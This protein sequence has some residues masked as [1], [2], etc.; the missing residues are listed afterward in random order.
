MGKTYSQVRPG[1]SCCYKLIVNQ[2]ATSTRGYLTAQLALPL[3]L[4]LLQSLVDNDV[5]WVAVGVGT[6]WLFHS[7][8]SLFSLS[9]LAGQ[10]VM[11]A[12]P[13]VPAVP[14]YPAPLSVL[15]LASALG[16]LPLIYGHGLA[17]LSD[18]RRRR[19][20][21]RLRQRCS[22]SGVSATSAVCLGYACPLHTHSD[23]HTH[24][25]RLNECCK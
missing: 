7:L 1:A 2:D 4:L 10:D 16:L 23:T 15:R 9:L 25:D 3:P 6:P 8:P 11:A 24:T 17:R 20:Q 14:A 5:N 12:N 13:L 22:D 21:R 19:R 18:R